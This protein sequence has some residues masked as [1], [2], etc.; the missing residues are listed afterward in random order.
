MDLLDIPSDDDDQTADIVATIAPAASTTT[1]SLKEDF[2]RVQGTVKHL[3]LIQALFSEQHKDGYMRLDCKLT[4]IE[5]DARKKSADNDGIFEELLATYLDVSLDSLLSHAEDH[6]I[7][8][9]SKHWLSK[10]KKKKL[11]ELFSCTLRAHHQG[12]VDQSNLSP[13]K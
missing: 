5:L 7:R 11:T 8:A 2:M 4:R 1:P 6:K 10:N 3:R 9:D 12:N 13:G